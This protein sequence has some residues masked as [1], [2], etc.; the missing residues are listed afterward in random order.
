MEGVQG[1]PGHPGFI[2]R[3]S[4]PGWALVGDAS[5]FKD[6]ITAHGITDALRDAELLARAI[7]AGTAAAF[8]EYETLRL[9]LSRQLFEVTDRIASFQWTDDELAALHKAFSKE[10]AREVH[11]LADLGPLPAIARPAMV[12]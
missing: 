3:S 7:I 6:P 12:M 8:A 2:R 4:G 9:D 11:V 1:F 5:Y 10:M